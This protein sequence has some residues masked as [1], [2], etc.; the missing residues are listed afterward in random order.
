MVDRQPVGAL[1]EGD[2]G[3]GGKVVAEPG[4]DAAADVVAAGAGEVVVVGLLVEGLGDEVGEAEDAVVIAAGTV[5]AGGFVVGGEGE[6]G[7]VWVERALVRKSCSEAEKCSRS[8][9]TESRGKLT[10][11]ALALPSSPCLRSRRRSISARFA[12]A[13]LNSRLRSPKRIMLV[14][15]MRSTAWAR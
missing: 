13:V 5:L 9:W 4:V 7:F 8:G 6:A 10:R 1:G 12:A 3:P 15:Y 14:W 2:A 11:A